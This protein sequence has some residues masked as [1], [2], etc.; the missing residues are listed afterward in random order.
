[1]YGIDTN[2]EA[3]NMNENPV[4]GKRV[5]NLRDSILKKNPDLVNLVNNNTNFNQGGYFGNA[6][7]ISGGIGSVP[8]FG[9]KPVL[10]DYKGGGTHEQNPLGGI[11]IGKARVEEGEERADLPDGSYIFSNRF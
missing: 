1:M 6:Y 2:K 11:P 10:T 7:S 3:I 4:Y 9:D 8:S 5:V